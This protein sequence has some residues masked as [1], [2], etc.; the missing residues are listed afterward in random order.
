MRRFFLLLSILLIA[1]APAAATPVRIDFSGEFDAALDPAELLYDLPFGTPFTGFVE[2]D[3]SWPETFEG[4]YLSPT[5]TSGRIRITFAGGNTTR[6]GEVSVSVVNDGPHGDELVI[7]TTWP[8]TS[9]FFTP[10]ETLRF[11]L[12]IV[13]FRDPTGAMFSNEFLPGDLPQGLAAQVETQGCRWTAPT[14]FQYCNALVEDTFLASL[15]I[16]SYTMVPEPAS[17]LLVALGIS[18]LARA[19]SR[20][21]DHTNCSQ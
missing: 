12:V 5:A 4:T 16:D 7:S 11:D 21:G 6:L 13:A 8:P 19:R 18:L 2:Y 15:R 3:T 10:W 20:Y 14:Q 1:A 17:A 9:V